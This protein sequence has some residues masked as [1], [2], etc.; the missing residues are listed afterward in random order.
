MTPEPL[1]IKSLRP[2]DTPPYMTG[3]WIG[4]MRWAIGE[5]DIVAMF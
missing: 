3:A 4:C 5:P 2:V 1:D